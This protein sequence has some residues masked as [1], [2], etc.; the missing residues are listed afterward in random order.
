MP[1]MKTRRGAAKRFGVT[2]TGKLKRRKAYLR[3]ILTNKTR[4]QKRHLGKSVV[5]DKTNEKALRKLLPYM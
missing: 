2:G 4:K 1:K 3:H 5:V